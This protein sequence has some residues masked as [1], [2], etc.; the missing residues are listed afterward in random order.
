MSDRYPKWTYSIQ[1]LNENQLVL[2]QLDTGMVYMYMWVTSKQSAI[3]PWCNTPWLISPHQACVCINLLPKSSLTR[4]KLT[5]FPYFSQCNIGFR[6][7]LNLNAC[8]FHSL[9][10]F[11]FF[12]AILP[13]S[14][15][16]KHH[17]KLIN[18]I[19]L[20]INPRWKIFWYLFTHLQLILQN[21]FYIFPGFTLLIILSPMHCFFTNPG[22]KI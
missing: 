17:Q 4:Y 7:F 3:Y 11:F 19:T 10:F 15:T 8:F 14:N 5:H 1:G 22:N 2:N 20:Y 16:L 21:A 12:L 18:S 9:G 6:R 13:R